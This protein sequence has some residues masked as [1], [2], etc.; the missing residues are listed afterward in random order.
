VKRVRVAACA[1]VGALTL[2]LSGCG[3]QTG[4]DATRAHTL[5][6]DV[7]AVTNAARTENWDLARA[8]I[9][10]TQT[11][12]DAALDAGQVSGS[13]YR[14]IEAAL[15]RVAALVAAERDGASAA[16]PSASP[17]TTPSA[18]KR[19]TTSTTKA[20]PSHAASTAPTNQNG[21]GHGNGKGKG[22]GQKHTP[23]PP[24]NK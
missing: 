21:P 9:A 4:L 5:Q 17:V 15:A 18:T 3:G 2:T 8:K 10:S 1:I 11:H 20:T 16:N 13:R 22:S 23:K 7:L 12:L 24:K 19:P 14:E 6:A